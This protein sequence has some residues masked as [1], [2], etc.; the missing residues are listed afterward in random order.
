MSPL[1]K[2]PLIRKHVEEAKIYLPYIKDGDKV[3]D[4]GT[5]VGFP[6]IPLAILKPDASFYLVD[7]KKTH[8]DFLN[9]V[10]NRLGLA[11]VCIF[12]IDANS[13]AKI[14]EKFDVVCSRAVN[15]IKVILDWSSPV[16]KENGVVLLG[17]KRD[18][19][20]E[21]EDSKKLSFIIQEIIPEDFGQLVVF[22][23]IQ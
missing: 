6:G 20:Q 8:T 5:G 16:I 23:K 22:K 1:E 17:K 12:N 19:A 3:L 10:R 2:D 11:N 4:I 14:N 15:R 9:E 18:V 13:L 21:I 7:R